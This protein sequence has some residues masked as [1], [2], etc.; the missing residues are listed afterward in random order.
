MNQIAQSLTK[1]IK[2][3]KWLSIDYINREGGATSYWCAIN[4]FI[5]FTFI[6]SSSKG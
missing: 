1:A 5:K 4:R 2:E 6:F 3:A